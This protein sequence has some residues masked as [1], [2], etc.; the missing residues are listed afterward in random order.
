[1]QQDGAYVNRGLDWIDVS[2]A[3]GGVAVRPTPSLRLSVEG[4]YKACD[5]YRVSASDPRISL[6]NLGG[7]FGTV[8]AEPLT[9]DGLGRAYGIELSAQKRLTSRVYGLANYTLGWSEFT[10][11]DGIYRPSA[12]DVRH[13]ASLTGGVRLRG[14]EIGTRL[15]VLSGRPFTPFDL[16]AS[17]AEYAVSRQGVRDLD[18][19]NTERTP[20]YSRLDLRVDRRFAIGRRVNGVVYVDVQNVLDRENVFSVQYTQD[21]AEPDFLRDQTNVGR[22]PTI[23]FSVEF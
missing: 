23:G 20:V 7:D 5:N 21:P 17:A 6:A 22:L 4:Y 11:A 15:T 19:L 8:G 9:S 3:V 2:Q 13:N 14:G 12:W 1:M 10:G 18:R 16:A